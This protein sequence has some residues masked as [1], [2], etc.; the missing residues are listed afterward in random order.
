MVR[1][2]NV[3]LPFAQCAVMQVTEYFP[4]F[5]KMLGLS[6]MK[7]CSATRALHSKCQESVDRVRRSSLGANSA[8]CN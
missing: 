4:A 5:I 7:P 3:Q 8:A 6:E 2:Y 1:T